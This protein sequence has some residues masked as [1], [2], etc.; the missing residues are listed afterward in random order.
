[1]EVLLLEITERALRPCT[2]H[3][4]QVEAK[5][6]ER[7]TQAGH[8]EAEQQETTA[9]QNTPISQNDKKRINVV[10]LSACAVRHC[11]LVVLVQYD[12]L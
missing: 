6:L 4:L 12:L 8:H 10:N 9:V 11:A 3:S 2:C 7:V 5:D 1:M